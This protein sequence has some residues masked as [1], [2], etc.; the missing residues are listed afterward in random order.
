MLKISYVGY[1]TQEVKAVR[2]MKIILKEDSE[3][4]S[5]VVVVG[6]GSQKEPT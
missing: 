2:T 1:Q 6:Y 3:I 4:L 5:E